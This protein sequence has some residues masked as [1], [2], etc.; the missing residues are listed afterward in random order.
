M[1]RV[2]MLKVLRPEGA[3]PVV[4][5]LLG[6]LLARKPQSRAAAPFVY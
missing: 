2:G 6:K 3:T 1:D 5:K 4:G